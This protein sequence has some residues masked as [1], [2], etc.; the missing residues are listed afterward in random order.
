[1]MYP[2]MTLEDGTEVVHSD[3]KEAPDGPHVL[4]HFERPSADGFDSVRFELPTYEL[5]LWGAR[6]RRRS[7][8]SCGVSCRRTPISSTGT[9]PRE[10]FRLP[11]LFFDTEDVAFFC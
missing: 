8:R 4:V 9:P 5:T 11:S 6:F 1:M 3:L 2:Y 10:G 7:S